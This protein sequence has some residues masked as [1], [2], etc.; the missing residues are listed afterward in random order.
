MDCSAG[1]A[2]EVL[3]FG[4]GYIVGLWGWKASQWISYKKY[5][6]ATLNSGK[7]SQIE[8]KFCTIRGKG[9]AAPIRNSSTFSGSLSFFTAGLYLVGLSPVPRFLRLCW[10]VWKLLEC[11]VP[12]SLGTRTPPLN[13]P[14]LRPTSLL[15]LSLPQNTH[16]L[17]PTFLRAQSFSLAS[18]HS[19]LFPC[20]FRDS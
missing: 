1:T 16:R 6:V 9:M 4:S 3:M 15:F 11:A 14:L 10:R 2:N 18:P 13:S 5:F 12:T 19:P 8:T 7:I 20:T 17:L